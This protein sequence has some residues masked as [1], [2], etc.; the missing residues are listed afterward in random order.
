M[1]GELKR[2]QWNFLNINLE[3][4][5]FRIENKLNISFYFGKR[6][7]KEDKLNKSYSL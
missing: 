5:R 6:F 1:N 2:L 7:K 4:V 3:R